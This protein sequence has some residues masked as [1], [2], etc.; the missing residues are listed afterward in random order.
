MLES[1]TLRFEAIMEQNS[2]WTSPQKRGLSSLRIGWS[3][4]MKDD[5]SHCYFCGLDAALGCQMR[6]IG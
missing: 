2:S 1:L 3:I 4:S 6:S 5:L